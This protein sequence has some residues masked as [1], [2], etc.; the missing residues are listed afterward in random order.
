LGKIFDNN[1]SG[2]IGEFLKTNVF[3]DAEIDLV[4]SMF[5]LYAFD[6]LKKELSKTNKVRFLYNEPTFLNGSTFF[7]KDSKIFVL[8]MKKTFMTM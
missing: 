1:K 7:D 8:E 5:T 3:K 4:S 6:K 2:Q